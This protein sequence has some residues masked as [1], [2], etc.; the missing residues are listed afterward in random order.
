MAL[1]RFNSGSIGRLSFEHLNEICDTID[2]LRPLLLRNAFMLDGTETETLWA[3]ILPYVGTNNYGD[4]VWEEVIPKARNNLVWSCQWETR[5]GGRKS[6][7]VTTGDKYEPAYAPSGFTFNGQNPVRIPVDTVVV[8]GRM[9]GTDGKIAWQIISPAAPT[10]FPAM[11]T[12]AA[13][14][15]TAPPAVRR[16]AYQ[17]IEVTTNDASSR[18]W[19]TKPNGRKSAGAPGDEPFA[20]NGCEQANVHGIGG[21]GPVGT[22]ESNAPVSAGVVV[23]MSYDGPYPFFSVPNGLNITC[24][25]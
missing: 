23:T 7:A 10:T 14:R 24:P 1:P 9:K 12:S 15:T 4:H 25:P 22:V 20:V 18:E 6:G 2:R 21:T 5:S 3:R 11:I 16:W 17:W 8:L 19:I 13:P